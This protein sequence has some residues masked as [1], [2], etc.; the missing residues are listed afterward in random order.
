MGCVSLP[1]KAGGVLM[2]KE[3]IAFLAILGGAKVAVKINN[4]LDKVNEMIIGG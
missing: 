3:W 4:M 2:K 1:Q